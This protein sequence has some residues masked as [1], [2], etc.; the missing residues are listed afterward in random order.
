MLD[1]AA[2]RLDGVHEVQAIQ[3][4]SEGCC[5][6]SLIKHKLMCSETASLVDFL[7]KADK[8]TTANSAMHVNIDDR[9]VRAGSSGCPEANCREPAQAAQRP[10]RPTQ[11]GLAGPTPQQPVGGDHGGRATSRSERGR[12]A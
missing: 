5:D 6:G 8:Y 10:Q 7:I 12:M 4:F 9:E 2:K 3:Y 1:R 11:E